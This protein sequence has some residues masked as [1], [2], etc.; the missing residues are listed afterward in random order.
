MFSSSLVHC[1]AKYKCFKCNILRQQKNELKI[2]KKTPKKK[3]N[4]SNLSCPIFTNEYNLK[5]S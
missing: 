1:G 2:K 3:K 5:L 4:E